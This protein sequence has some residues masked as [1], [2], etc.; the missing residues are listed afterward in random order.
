MVMGTSDHNV[1]P[2]MMLKSSNGIVAR[3]WVMGKIAPFAQEH[4]LREG[5]QSIQGAGHRGTRGGA[6]P[7][8]NHRFQDQGQ[9]PQRQNWSLDD[10]VPKS[11][12]YA[13]DSEDVVGVLQ[14]RVVVAWDGKR[15]DAQSELALRECES[16]PKVQKL[17][18]R[19]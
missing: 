12:G 13:V 1:V 18:M 8:W 2:I 14:E 7:H 5:E 3:L 16:H 19:S 15:R 9:N 6:I 4:P 17:M 11:A 10:G